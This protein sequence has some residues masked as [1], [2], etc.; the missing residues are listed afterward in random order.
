MSGAFSCPYF[1][2][3]IVAVPPSLR[4]TRGEIVSRRH[5]GGVYLFFCHLPTSASTPSLR[6]LFFLSCLVFV[7]ARCR[8]RNRFFGVRRAQASFVRLSKSRSGY[9]W[10]W[11]SQNLRA[12][13]P[14]S[15]S[16]F[17]LSFSVSV[18]LLFSS[19]FFSSLLFCVCP[20]S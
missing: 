16:F 13:M 17:F 1:L 20:V 10:G 6:R 7:L 12:M 14:D 8:R 4:H 5:S 9:V 15:D 19:L 2:R 18:S 11:E 3:K